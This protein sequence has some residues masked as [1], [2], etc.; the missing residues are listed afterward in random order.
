MRIELRLKIKN[1][2]AIFTVQYT[3]CK[4]RAFQCLGAA[5]IK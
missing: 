1:E 4:G 3:V 5:V 2:G